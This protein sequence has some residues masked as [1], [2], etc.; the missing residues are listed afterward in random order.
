MPRIGS[1]NDVITEKT[2]KRRLGPP[3]TVYGEGLQRTDF[4]STLMTKTF[5]LTPVLFDILE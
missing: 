2:R 4:L 1:D 5:E 3:E